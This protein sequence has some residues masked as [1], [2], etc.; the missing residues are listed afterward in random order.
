MTGMRSVLLAMAIGF[1]FAT[2][3]S[4]L[5]WRVDAYVFATEKPIDQLS[6]KVRARGTH[7]LSLSQISVAD[8]LFPIRS[9]LIAGELRWE[10][11]PQTTCSTA[12]GWVSR[13]VF[14]HECRTQYTL[15]PCEDGVW[16][17]LT[18]GRLEGHP[19]GGVKLAVSLPKLVNCTCT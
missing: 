4:A 18:T 13:G 10:G 11:Q 6:S 3:G 7:R 2:L 1:L 8:Q 17:T 15:N 9:R 5:E 14:Y 12:W 16:T 19:K